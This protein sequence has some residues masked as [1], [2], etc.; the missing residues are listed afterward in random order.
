[1]DHLGDF[2]DQMFNDGVPVNH[3]F[4]ESEQKDE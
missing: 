3:V 1:M 4:E 2:K